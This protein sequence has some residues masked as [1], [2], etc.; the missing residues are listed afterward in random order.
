MEEKKPRAPRK[1]KSAAEIKAQMEK[2][3]AQLAAVEQEAHAD[4]LVELLTKHNVVSAIKA[5]ND[6]VRTGYIPI[7]NAI[8]KELKIA[9]LSITQA[10]QKKRAPRGSKQKA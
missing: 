5:V 7:L 3:Q 1:R 8:G 10:E 4:K 6:E 2:L 9:R